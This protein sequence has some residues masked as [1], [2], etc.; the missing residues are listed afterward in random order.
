MRSGSAEREEAMAKR[1]AL[2]AHT[3]GALIMIVDHN[4]EAP[5]AHQAQILL[6]WSAVDAFTRHL[7]SRDPHGKARDLNFPVRASA[8]KAEWTV[9]SGT[10][11]ETDAV[12]KPKVRS[13]ETNTMRVTTGMLPGNPG[14]ADVLLSLTK[15][16][17]G[18]QFTAV[19]SEDDVRDLCLPL[20]LL[21][22]DHLGDQ[23]NPL[24][25]EPAHRSTSVDHS[26]GPNP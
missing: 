23:Q 25:S 10:G 12:P 18:D 17:T 14:F 15:R 11:D 13:F 9:A 26:R 5:W 19:L 21:W 22:T 1:L 6:P 2:S 7:G 3:N 16:G 8:L 20:I 4:A 24:S